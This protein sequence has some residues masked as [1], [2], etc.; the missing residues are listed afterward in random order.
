MPVNTL[1]FNQVSTILNNIMQQATGQTGIVAVNTG[2]FVSIAQTTLLAG[3]DTV[4][5]AINQVLTRTIFSQR[6]YYAKFK[7]LEISESAW[8][9]WIRKLSI[10]DSAFKDDDAYAWP[11]G[12]DAGQTP[13]DGNGQSVDPYVIQKP[14]VIQTNFYGSSVYENS[15]TVTDYQLRQAFSGP[16]ELGSFL[17]LILTNRSDKLEQARENLA[18]QTLVNL[19]GGIYAENNSDR[20][21]PMLTLYNA[22]TGL[23]L[24]AQSVYQPA[25]WPGFVRWAYSLVATISA[26]MTERS[27]K[28]QT[29]I[30]TKYIPRHTP[31]EDQRIFLF[32]PDRFSMEM[33][34]LADTYHDNYLRMAVTETVN[35]W[36][37]IDT[38][39]HIICTPSYT[40]TAGTLVT[41]SVDT[42]TDDAPIFGCIID[43]QAAGFA[44]TQMS[45]E[46]ARN[47][48]GKYTTY[49]DHATIR[50]FNDNTEKGVVLLMA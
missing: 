40:G 48:R 22:A 39:A 5:N 15:Y 49:W 28:Y 41:G 14:D 17:T 16:E 34:A 47:P 8:G 37:N 4:L 6:P 20:V 25:N 12:Y 29:T 43:R 2:D 11:V 42:V 18:R 50:C 46:P 32:A 1:S 3:P 44:V 13:P 36:Q 38:P 31:Y 30:G 7:G 35:F 27:V 45:S 26:A 9:N 19:I 24:T 10:A 21:I 23:S 33:M